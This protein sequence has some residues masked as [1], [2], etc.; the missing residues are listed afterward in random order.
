MF[1]IMIMNSISCS[2]GISVFSDG[3]EL[4]ILEHWSIPKLLRD[5]G[6]I[7]TQEVECDDII[8]VLIAENPYSEN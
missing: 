3:Y 5:E 8:P 4:D 2:T 7:L 1:L 6:E